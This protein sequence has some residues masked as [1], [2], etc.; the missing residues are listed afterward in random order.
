MMLSGTRARIALTVLA[1][2]PL[3][4][5]CAA[6]ETGGTSSASCVFAVDYDD[7][8]YVDAGKVRHTLGAEVGTARDSVCEDQGGGE[9]DRVAPGDLGDYTAY[10]IKGVDTEDAIA[11]RDSPEGEVRVVVRMGGDGGVRETAER[12]FGKDARGGDGEGTDVNDEPG[13]DTGDGGSDS[14]D[15]GGADVGK[16]ALVV[17]YGNEEYI[18]R[19]DARIELGARAGLARAVP[20]WD[21]P[22]EVDPSAEPQAYRAYEIKGLDPADAIA[23]RFS[24]DE[25]PFFMVRVGDDLPPEVE[26]LL[27]AEEG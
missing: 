16:C 23:I 9:E 24:A 13:D 26:A 20:C 18:G 19:G 21:T 6:L 2:T 8:T 17:E 25:K 15:G 5:G 12:L 3:A 11:V 7:R 4:V 14:G 1:M 10:A 22:G 27:A